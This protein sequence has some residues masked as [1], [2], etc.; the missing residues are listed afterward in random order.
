MEIFLIYVIIRNINKNRIGSWTNRCKWTSRHANPNPDSHCTMRVRIRV[1]MIVYIH[2]FTCIIFFDTT[3]N[4]QKYKNRKPDRKPDPGTTGKIYGWIVM[5]KL[6]SLHGNLFGTI[7]GS[8][9][10]GNRT[11]RKIY[12]QKKYIEYVYQILL[13]QMII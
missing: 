13:I 9:K 6:I 4:L 7:R 3:L 11:N 1:C 2:K 5:S 8:T 12:S 10:T